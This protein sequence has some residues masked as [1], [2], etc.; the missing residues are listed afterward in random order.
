MFR[1]EYKMG[2]INKASFVHNEQ[3]IFFL[4]SVKTPLSLLADQLDIKLTFV[5]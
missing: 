2:I 3:G 1:K 5:L 4:T